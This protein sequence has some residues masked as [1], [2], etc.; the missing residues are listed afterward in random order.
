MPLWR[1]RSSASGLRLTA[2]TSWGRNSPGRSGWIGAGGGPF[3]TGGGFGVGAPLAAGEVGG[4]DPAGVGPE[5]VA[6]LVLAAVVKVGAAAAGADADFAAGAVAA[7]VFDW[8][9]L[10]NSSFNASATVSGGALKIDG[11]STVLDLEVASSVFLAVALLLDVAADAAA[12]FP[13]FAGWSSSS[14]SSCAR[15]GVFTAAAVDFDALAA[16][17]AVDR[18]VPSDFGAPLD[19]LAE[20]ADEPDVLEP[21]CDEDCDFAAA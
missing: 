2:S 6:G 8:E 20:A 12:A 19:W 15:A 21:D 9:P 4:G 3:A 16:V 14:S 18:S 10:P 1:A 7:P 5:V 13:D 17:E 11:F